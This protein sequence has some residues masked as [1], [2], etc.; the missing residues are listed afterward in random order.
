MFSFNKLT[1]FA[2]V[3]AAS[4]V[5][6]ATP[7]SVKKRA[8]LDVFVPPI[9]SPVAGDVWVVGQQKNVTWDTSNAPAHITNPIGQILLAKGG[10]IT[11]DVLADGFDILIG[12]IEVTVPDV[13]D[14]DDYAIILLGDASNYSPE[15]TITHSA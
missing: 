11:G 14:G 7:A 12:S 6:L 5:V 10:P 9:T 4:S 3:L 8:A 15:F 1:V 13:V 2:T